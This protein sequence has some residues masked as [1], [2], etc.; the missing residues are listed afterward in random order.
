M[1]HEVVVVA[2]S[3]VRVSASRGVSIKTTVPVAYIGIVASVATAAAVV[4]VV[5]VGVRASGSGGGV[6]Q[7]DLDVGVI[8]AVERHL[9]VV[10]V[11]VCHHVIS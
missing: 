4:V 7:G 9:V 8:N 2:C 3:P 11:L 1:L 10:A 5:A 6:R